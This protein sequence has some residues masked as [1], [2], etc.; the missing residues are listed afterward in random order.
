MWLRAENR[1]ERVLAVRVM[2]RYGKSRAKKSPDGLWGEL[3][4]DGAHEQLPFDWTPV[5][6]LVVVLR[7]EGVPFGNTNFI[8]AVNAAID[9]G[10]CSMGAR[11]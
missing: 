3:F 8:P 7:R 2:R 6:V 4:L 1:P 11:I 5:C 10:V 9:P